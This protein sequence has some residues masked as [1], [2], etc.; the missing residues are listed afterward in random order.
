M[1][2]IHLYILSSI[3]KYLTTMNPNILILLMRIFDLN[4][5][6]NINGFLMVRFNVINIS[7]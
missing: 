4:I 6:N 7:F 1:Q 2:F 5:E 3:T